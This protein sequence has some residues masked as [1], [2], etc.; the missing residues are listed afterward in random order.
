MDAPEEHA[1]KHEYID[2]TESDTASAY[3]ESIHGTV[4]LQFNLRV[5]P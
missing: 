1:H 2:I 5:T 3:G 4:T